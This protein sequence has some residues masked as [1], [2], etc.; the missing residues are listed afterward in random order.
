[1]TASTDKMLT[2]EMRVNQT[3][4]L[5]AVGRDPIR[6]QSR[7]NRSRRVLE[8]EGIGAPRLGKPIMNR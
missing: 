6:V 4:T 3:G 1:M 8:M 7:P 5:N 2:T